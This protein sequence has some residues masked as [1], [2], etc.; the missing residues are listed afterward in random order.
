M[1]PLGSAA[2]NHWQSPDP[3]VR[4]QLPHGSSAAEIKHQYHKLCLIYH[5][6]KSGRDTREAFV[7]I[8]EAFERLMGT[9]EG[10]W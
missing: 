6:D 10:G 2:E 9:R 3:W 5:P 8:T 4:L 7:A 1:P